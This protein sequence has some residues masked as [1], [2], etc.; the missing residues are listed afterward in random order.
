MR[1]ILKTE[2]R[3]GHVQKK[4]LHEHEALFTFR[5][6]PSRNANHSPFWFWAWTW[7]NCSGSKP[8]CS[9]SRGTGDY[10]RNRTWNRKRRR[11]ARR[12]TSRTTPNRRNP[13]ENETNERRKNY[14]MFRN[15]IH[16]LDFF[17]NQLWPRRTNDGNVIVP[18]RSQTSSKR[19]YIEPDRI[20]FCTELSF[21]TPGKRAQVYFKYC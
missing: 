17:L 7:T 12:P 13:L 1:K 3:R 8:S 4:N 2:P 16:H 18:S 5:C 11:S 9:C 15:E 10:P 6:Y 19:N 21:R 14:R 20:T